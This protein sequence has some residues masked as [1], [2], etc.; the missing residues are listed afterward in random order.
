MRIKKQE[1]V[2]RLFLKAI[3]SPNKEEFLQQL[4][5]GSERDSV[6]AQV[7]RLLQNHKSEERL[8][9]MESSIR[10]PAFKTTADT[11][12][13]QLSDDPESPI[14]SSVQPGPSDTATISGRCR[15]RVYVTVIIGLASV[16]IVLTAGVRL[17]RAVHAEVVSCLEHTMRTLLDQ[18]VIAIRTWLTAEQRLVASWCKNPAVVAA[19]ENLDELSTLYVEPR[20]Q[21]RD[22]LVQQRLHSAVQAGVGSGFEH[23]FAVWNREGTLLADSCPLHQDFLGNGLTEYGA[24]LLSRVFRGETVLWLP[25]E[26][27]FI[28][29]R[30]E[31][32]GNVK[33]PGIAIIAPVI[34][35]SGRPFAAMLISSCALQKRLE[36]IMRPARVG[37]FTDGFA[38]AS[39][40]ILLTESRFAKQLLAVGL[41]F[42]AGAKG[43]AR[44]PRIADP[45]GNLLDGYLPSTDS[46]DWPHTRAVSSA[47]LG[48]SG[49]D[50]SGYRDCRG[51]PVVGVWHWLPDYRIGV[52]IEIEREAAFRPLLLVR[53]A[54]VITTL[55]ILGLTIG[56]ALIL[57][58]RM[59]LRRRLDTIQVVGYQL[60]QLL[61]EG[62][63]SR[64]Y[65]AKHKML[66]R[67]TAIKI[68]KRN[69][70]NTRNCIRFKR[71]VQLASTLSH[72]NTV[73]IFDC[74][75][76]SDGR[77][78]Y[79]M[80]FV[81][82]LS[83]LEVIQVDGPQAPER[84]IL[85]LTQICQALREVHAEGLI[86][87]DIKPQNVMLC[88]RGGEH[89]VVKVL[90]FG[91]AKYLAAPDDD[92]VTQTQLLVGTPLYIAPERIL[93]PACTDPRSDIYSIG[94]LG[95]FLLVGSEPFI[96]LGSVDA[97][98]QTM[99]QSAR[100]P[101]AH[102]PGPIP[103]SL[104]D[105]IL[106]CHSKNAEDRPATIDDV[107][108]GLRHIHC[109]NPWTAER[110]ELWWAT[111]RD[112]AADSADGQN[113]SLSKTSRHI[114]I[115]AEFV[116]HPSDDG[117]RK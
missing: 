111:Y 49:E 11:H 36:D 18:Q 70:M 19:V 32:R 3:A 80:E 48:N 114:E 79:A 103:E 28:T 61:G 21:L 30:F 62:G 71:E 34:D 98:T 33:Q 2:H 91:L 109:S 101:S 116:A 106:K 53:R 73:R 94:I 89:D 84:V 42:N 15:R 22:S 82:G 77:F 51:I 115:D 10:R 95:Y 102:C 112:V 38:F 81:E 8:L 85:I 64:V 54:F 65:L 13:T 25:T 74:G 52:A 23:Q 96:A 46:H 92:K 29:E 26:G 17:D 39:D 1:R 88:Q 99:C 16:I 6:V 72:P 75:Q 83:L 93:N 110:A 67:P 108:T 37:E 47:L 58:I 66:N 41:L 57:F 60:T 107:L 50:F 104:D 12:R 20:D 9:E 56:V 27:E 68:M 76:A 117:R 86:H 14:P 44:T 63:F 113:D 5:R 100:R 87:R 35:D 59:M 45:G 105:L 90:D 97:L 4:T 24:G 7:R 78:F 69:Q 31:L 55:S 40:G 43:L